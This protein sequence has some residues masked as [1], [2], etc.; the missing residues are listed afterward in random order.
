MEGTEITIT[1]HSRGGL[2]PPPAG[3]LIYAT[4]IAVGPLKAGHYGVRAVMAGSELIVREFNVAPAAVITSIEPRN[5]TVAGGAPVTIRGMNLYQDPICGPFP[6]PCATTTV[7]FGSTDVPVVSHSSDAIVVQAPPHAAGVVDLTVYRTDGRT[8]TEERGFLFGDRALEKWLIPV[9]VPDVVDGALG[10]RWVTELELSNRA[11]VPA[12]FFVPSSFDLE[13]SGLGQYTNLSPG[14]I[15]ATPPMPRFPGGGA[16]V[17]V[18]PIA[19]RSLAR[20]LRVRD[21]S[22]DARAFA[23]PVPIVSEREGFIGSL[24]FLGVPTDPQYRINVRL[25]DFAGELGHDF[26]VET[27]SVSGQRLGIF[28]GLTSR[29][30]AETDPPRWPGY[31]EVD[32]LASR[33]PA[34]RKENR[35]DV[36]VGS[37]HM[38]RWW[39]MLTITDNRTQ[40]VTIVTPS[41]TDLGAN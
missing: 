6:G 41:G 25:Y 5:A 26:Y 4:H 13:P 7:A 36:V 39:A 22:V 38:R 31:G 15:F 2:C 3:G 1:L 12:L 37:S 9:S 20:S 23:A 11:S 19:A 35:V 18:D 33:L 24:L 40:Q 34:I 16:F 30:D 17:Y 27:R 32:D 28:H 10:S 8:A 14:E 21:L 29:N